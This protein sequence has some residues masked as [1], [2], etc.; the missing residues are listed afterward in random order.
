MLYDRAHGLPEA[1]K[2]ETICLC[3]QKQ[4]FARLYKDVL[5]IYPGKTPLTPFFSLSCHILFT[6]NY[7]SILS[8]FFLPSNACGDTG[9]TYILVPHNLKLE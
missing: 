6:G 3:S 9:S 8:S 4:A 5:Q 2:G 1:C 7:I